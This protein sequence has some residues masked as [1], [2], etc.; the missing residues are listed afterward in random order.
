MKPCRASVEV[1]VVIDVPRSIAGRCERPAWRRERICGRC[2]RGSWRSWPPSSAGAW[3][4]VN[5]AS[6]LVVASATLSQIRNQRISPGQLSRIFQDRDYQP[7]WS[8]TQ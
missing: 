7:F 6:G 2:R 8:T 3:M 4:L 1:S 5:W